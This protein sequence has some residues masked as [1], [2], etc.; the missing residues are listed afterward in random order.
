MPYFGQDDATALSNIRAGRKLEQ[1]SEGISDPVWW[2]L[3]R[4]WR[5][6]PSQRPSAA[7]V[8]D[9]FSELRS[10]PEKLKLQVQSVKIP[11]NKP[12][13]QG[14]YVKFKYGNMVHTTSLTTKVVA[15]ADYAWFVF[16][17]FPP[18][19][20]SLSLGQEHSGNLVDNNQRASSRTDHLLPS[21]LP[22]I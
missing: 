12:R 9:V 19:L 3:E 8:Y 10:I 5:T 22:P 1:P 21:A 11:L 20:S 2:L 15:G 14:V 4:C 16:C 18:L 13:Q 17:P 7:E 6:V